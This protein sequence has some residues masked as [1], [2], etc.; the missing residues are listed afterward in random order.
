M[1]GSHIIL[2]FFCD[3]KDIKANILNS[4]WIE[5]S[6]RSR[7][8]GK[9][10]V[11]WACFVQKSKCGG[12]CL[13]VYGNFDWWSRVTFN[14]SSISVLTQQLDREQY[15]VKIMLS[16][17]RLCILCIGSSIRKPNIIIKNNNHN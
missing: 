17:C 5:G 4:K 15:N 8:G 1:K 13:W 14:C 2:S 12:T 9:R 6:G 3:C 11:G 16:E 7:L 10:V